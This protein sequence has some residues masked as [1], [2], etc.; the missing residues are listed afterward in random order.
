M[1]WLD[2]QSFAAF[3]FH[4]LLGVAFFVVKVILSCP[5]GVV[6]LWRSSIFSLDQARLV[7]GGDW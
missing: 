4:A 2:G 1:A 6:G 5:F 3:D 7:Y